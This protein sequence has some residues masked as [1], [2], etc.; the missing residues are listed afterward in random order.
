MR[1]SMLWRLT[2]VVAGEAAER[3]GSS[4]RGLG[5][6][7]D[8]AVWRQLRDQETAYSA[9]G[10]HGGSCLVSLAGWDLAVETQACSMATGA[11]P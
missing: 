2:L 6:G 7:E 9:C 1:A 5:I 10:D 11:S 4:R 3:Q 8:E